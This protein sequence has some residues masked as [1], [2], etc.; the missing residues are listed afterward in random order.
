MVSG[1]PS[2]APYRLLAHWHHPRFG[3]GEHGGN[4]FMTALCQ[5]LQDAGAE[6]VLSGH[7]GYERFA[8]Q[9]AGGTFGDA[10]TDSCLC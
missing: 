3:S 4:I 1:R 9:T 7:H 6:I 8:P 10:G 5:N 2:C